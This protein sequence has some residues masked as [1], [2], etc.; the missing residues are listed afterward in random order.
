MPSVQDSTGQRITVEQGEH[1][2]TFFTYMYLLTV[3]T[4]LFASGEAGAARDDHFVY[5]MLP[6]M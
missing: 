3:C 4:P 2:T 5:S 6:Y 1:R